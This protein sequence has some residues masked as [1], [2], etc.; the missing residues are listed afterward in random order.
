MTLDDATQARLA[1]A[2]RIWN[3]A[4]VWALAIVLAQFGAAAYFAQAL[5]P[6]ARVPLHFDIAGHVNHWGSGRQAARVMFIV[7]FVSLCVLGALRLIT[8]TGPRR[9]GLAATPR[10][11]AAVL[12]GVPLMLLAVVIVIG[13]SM[14]AP[15]PEAAIGWRVR[16]VL[17][18]WGA[19]FAGLGNFLGKTHRNWWMGV[20]TPWSLSSDLAWAKSNRLAGRI[21]VLTGLATMLAASFAGVRMATIALAGGTVVMALSAVYVSWAVWRRDPN[22]TA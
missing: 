5:W 6:L 1:R 10:L 2:D 21:M 8:K 17:G 15:A 14:L 11:F 22:R 4:F 3:G 16:I 12:V 9:E 19:L 20:R 13:G 7:P 18:L